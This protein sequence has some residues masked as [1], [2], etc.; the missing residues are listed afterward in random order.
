MTNDE[1]N[2]IL[3]D[4]ISETTEILEDLENS[5]VDLEEN[6]DDKELI[7]KIFRSA[8][9]IKGSSA[10]LEL[11]KLS[12]ISHH[13]EDILNK[14]RK[15]EIALTDVI[16]D[17]LLEYVDLAKGIVENIKT[18]DDT[19][20]IRE[21]LKKIEGV[22][23]GEYV[24]TA[25][26]EQKIS[27]KKTKDGGKQI[28]AAHKTIEQTIRVEVS[29][30]DALMNLVGELVLSRNRLSQLAID[31]NQKYRDDPI[32]EQ[33]V[34]TTSQLGLV[35]SDLQIAVMK[36]RMIPIS[37]VFSRFP[38]IVRDVAR[39][40]KKDVNLVVS[41][42]DTELDKSVIEL[43]TDPLVHMVR[44]A[45]DHGLET[46]EER[47]GKPKKGTIWLNAMQQGN[48][49]IIEVKDDG[50]GID[51]DKVAKSAL[52][53][54]LTTKEELARMDRDEI[55]GFIFRPGFSTS[56]KVT[57]ISGRGVGLDVVKNNIEKIN[58]IINIDSEIGKGTTIQL[59]LPLT[60]A[61][62]QS[63]LVEVSGEI[64][65]IPIVSILETIKVKEDDIH[66]L[67]GREVLNYRNGV[68]S[69]IR[70]TDVL[71][72]EESYS[73]FKYVV[74]INVAERQV[75]FV[76]N[77]LIGQEEIVIKTLGEFLGNLTGIAGATIMGDGKVRLILDPSGII[78]IASKMPR[79]LKKKRVRN[80]E[81]QKESITALVVD[82]S[83]TDRKIIKNILSQAGWINV[84]EV[85][86][87]KDALE[88]AKKVKFDIF[89]IDL[90]LPE[91]DGYELAKRLREKGL[92]QPFIAITVRGDIADEKQVK[93]AGFNKLV[94]KPI[95][96]NEILNTI[97]D[98]L[99]QRSSS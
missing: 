72:L 70:I 89:I 37:K 53:K 49:I 88:I 91:I 75:G 34:D 74:V 20:E 25:Q 41:G 13:T 80:V 85:P 12:T 17:V 90:V 78:E 6:K 38:R 30:L 4:F 79:K 87:G 99:S 15:D 52:E 23:S 40:L 94:L 26:K 76:V 95:N 18:G 81:S 64:F 24:S 59:K 39:D 65:A 29:R 68:L 71:E 61:I 9:T 96:M 36:T 63:L 60:L 33:L 56:E 57:N 92:D 58:G 31:L 43:I 82:D 62:I 48:H 11:E 16:M 42:E 51:P 73:D 93:M 3:Q 5:L 46:P 14:L 66:E 7:N 97:D 47:V 8:H 19:V 98:L 21:F 32:L 50:K 77:R 27:S 67:E 83:A 86:T 1:T 69:I 84:V 2:E 54:G 28:S 22:K 44:N 45:I 10:F 35:T 55:I